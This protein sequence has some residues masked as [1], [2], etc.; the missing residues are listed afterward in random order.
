[1][2]PGMRPSAPE[3]LVHNL[4]LLAAA[5]LVAAFLGEA[6]LRAAFPLEVQFVK[7]GDSFFYAPGA[8]F[9]SATH[10]FNAVFA[11]NSLGF[12]DRDH[13]VE[14]R[15]GVKRIAFLGDSF[16]QA[17][18]FPPSKKFTGLIE[19][20]L[21]SPGNVEVLNFGFGGTGTLEQN[22]YL[23]SVALGY[24][25]DVVVL[26]FFTNDVQDN[27]G[28]SRIQ[29]D[30]FR[31][32]RRELS[33]SSLFYRLLHKSLVLLIDSASNRPP[34]FSQSYSAS[35][36]EGAWNATSDALKKTQKL[37]SSSGARFLLAYL[38]AQYE[39][40]RE[41]LIEFNEKYPGEAFDFAY[42]SKRLRDFSA[43]EGIEFLDLSPFLRDYSQRTGEYLYFKQDGHLNAAGH[44]AVAEA[45]APAIER[46]L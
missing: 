35:G 3:S 5:L 10:E 41:A 32:W 2:K 7:R 8:E 36:G 18:H 29:G 28:Y 26:V 20:K 30:P 46:L 23:E 19:E 12:V 31:A 37:S 27:E 33:T 21:S 15:E 44:A 34:A 43:S 17:I 4:F 14:K 24:D 39:V 40:H 38:P 25:L 11:T 22:K 9:S 13:A 45:L 42:P 1:M 6:A 16:T